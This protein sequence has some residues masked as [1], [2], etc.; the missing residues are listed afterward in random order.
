MSPLFS[1]GGERVLFHKRLAGFL[2]VVEAHR[3]FP[4]FLHPGRLDSLLRRIQANTSSKSAVGS[5][6]LKLAQVN[7]SA[8]L[9]LSRSRS[10]HLTFDGSNTNIVRERI[11]CRCV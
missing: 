3:Y 1:H 11:V 6:S 4:I 8:G 10:A 2:P 7:S 9:L 5:L